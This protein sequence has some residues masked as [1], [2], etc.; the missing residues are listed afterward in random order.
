MS[1]VN[2]T[3]ADVIAEWELNLIR[4]KAIHHLVKF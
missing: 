1:G 3:V 4:S 2:N